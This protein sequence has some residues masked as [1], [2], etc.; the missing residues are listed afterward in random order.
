MPR[1]W[2]ASKLVKQAARNLRHAM[3]PAETRLWSVL[4]R[5]QI[6]NARF[7]RQRPIRHFIAD[8]CCVECRLIIEVDGAAHNLT[9]DQDHARQEWLEASGYRVIRF[10]NDDVMKNLD[11]VIEV[12][13]REIESLKLAP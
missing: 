10:S 2:R 7:R 3:T 1:E 5:R 8:F 6:A 11:G 9:G 4:R 13:R 12:V